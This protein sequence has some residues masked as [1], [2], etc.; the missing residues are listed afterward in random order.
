MTYYRNSSCILLWE[1]KIYSS[2]ISRYIAKYETLWKNSE[3]NTIKYSAKTNVMLLKM[4]WFNNYVYE[5]VSNIASLKII[6]IS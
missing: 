1:C 6:D 5:F 2:N 4:K 3:S